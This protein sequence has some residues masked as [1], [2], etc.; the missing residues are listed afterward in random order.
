MTKT[1]FLDQPPDSAVLTPYDREHLKIYLRLL[2]AEAD[3]ACWEEAV[4]VIFGLD[5]EKDAQR[6]ARVYTSHMARAKW[7]TENGFS[8][9]L[10]RRLH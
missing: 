9:L 10:G 7:M 3:G 2:D 4:T 1:N 5:P 6:A 8:E